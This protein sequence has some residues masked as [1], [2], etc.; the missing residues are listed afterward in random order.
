MSGWD[1]SYTTDD[2]GNVVGKTVYNDD[3]TVDE[4]YSDDN[5]ETHSHDKYSDMDTY[6]DSVDAAFNGE[7]S[8]GDIY[9]RDADEDSDNHPWTDYDG[10]L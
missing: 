8:D 5:F 6:I 2:D 7:D 3:G 10:V 9:S 4:Y 1:Y